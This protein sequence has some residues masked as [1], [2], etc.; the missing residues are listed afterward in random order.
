MRGLTRCFAE[1]EGVI[2]LD[3]DLLRHVLHRNSDTREVYANLKTFIPSCLSSHEACQISPIGFVPSRLLEVSPG[4][5]PNHI[6]LVEAT[7]DGQRTW[8]CLSYVW[9]GKQRHKTTMSILPQYLKDICLDVLPQTI[10]DAVSVCRELGIAYLWVDSFCIVQ[11]D[12]VDKAKEIPQMALIYRHALLTIAASRAHTVEDGYLH[13]VSPLCYGRFAPTSLRFRDRCGR[14][15]KMLVLTETHHKLV[16]HRPKEPIDARAW[17]LQEQLLSPR[18]LSY[19]SHGLRWSCRCLIQ[20]VNGHPDQVSLPR[21]VVGRIGE[22][23]PCIPGLEMK[24]WDSVV[25]LYSPRQ[26]TLHSDKLVALSAV[27]RTYSEENPGYGAYLAGIWERSLPLGLMWWVLT[28]DIRPRPLEYRA[29]SWSWASVDGAVQGILQNLE[30]DNYFKIVSA[31]TRTV[32]S[33]EFGAVTDGTL[34]VDARVRDCRV[35]KDI[36][37]FPSHLNFFNI[38]DGT[39]IIIEADTMEFRT[40]ICSEVTQVTL[41]FLARDRGW[42]H[43]LVLTKNNDGNSFSRVSRFQFEDVIRE[44]S[45]VEYKRFC[46]GFEIKRVVIV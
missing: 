40:L 13:H 32:D 7:S 14:E 24:P 20:H 37:K 26:A 2:D 30:V 6:R 41:M 4:S 38:L 22:I 33:N 8:A 12:E 9:G 17:A 10:K 5:D 31:R 35:V 23:V 21:S 15:S 39:E 45:Q 44:E 46:D 27:A 1:H 16:F 18:L 11:D 29:P 3:G 25:R 43:G 36:K 19:T 28:E 42:R 34:V